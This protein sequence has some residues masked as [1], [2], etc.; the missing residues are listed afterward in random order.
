MFINI[1]HCSSAVLSLSTPILS[2]L[3]FLQWSEWFFQNTDLFMLLNS[4][5]SF[6]LLIRSRPTCHNH[7]PWFLPGLYH[8][9]PFSINTS[10]LSVPRMCQVPYCHFSSCHRPLQL[11][12]SLLESSYPWFVLFIL[13]IKKLKNTSSND[14][15]W[16]SSWPTSFC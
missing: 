5:K 1:V 16:H 2:K 15:L 9:F 6:L 4:L 11:T 3:A 10:L 8:C 14:L 12:F 13:P 7:S